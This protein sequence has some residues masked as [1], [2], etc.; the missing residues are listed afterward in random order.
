MLYSY[1]Q[2]FLFTHV[3]RTGGVSIEHALRFAMPNLRTLGVQ[4]AALAE[5]R[6]TLGP[7]YDDLFTFAFVRN[8]WDRLVSWRGLLAG[9]DGT[10]AASVADPDAAHWREFE[11]FLADIIAETIEI[12]GVTRR[13]FSQFH[14]L[15]DAEEQ[16]LASQVGRFETLTEDAAAIFARAGLR[17]PPLTHE[18]RSAHLPYGTYYTAAARDM[19]A[20]AFAADVEAFG[21]R[22]E[23]EAA[24]V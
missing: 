11:G 10:P 3:A 8:P 19:V 14:Q 12:D 15:A 17:V 20:E 13:A 21:Y 22:F 16:L 9:L 5:A 18:N 24:V 4:H 23:G 6:A 1:Q 7:L 2:N